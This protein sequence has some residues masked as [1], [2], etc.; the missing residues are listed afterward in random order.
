QAPIDEAMPAFAP[1]TTTPLRMQGGTFTIGAAAKKISKFSLE[2]GGAVVA[3]PDV[4]AASGVASY[5]ITDFDPAVGFDLEA[6]L[7]A[8]YDINGIWLAGTEAAVVFAA[9]GGG[10]TVTIT[11]PKVQYKEVPEGDRD[12]IA[13][14]DAAG[15][16]N[17]DSGN[18][19]IAIVTT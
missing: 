14:Y 13:I 2:V 4:N 10:R 8:S 9:T 5:I 15:Q 17:N 16:C 7:V 6:E 1:S 12:G 11:C 18:D 19:A 3:Q